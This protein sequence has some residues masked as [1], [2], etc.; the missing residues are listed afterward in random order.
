MAGRQV[1]ELAVE[2]MSCSHCAA[3]VKDTIGSFPGVEGVEVDLENARVTIKGND[4][5]AS[6]LAREIDALGFTAEV[7]S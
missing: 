2:G 4:L 7:R 6:V 5:D 3:S 1:I